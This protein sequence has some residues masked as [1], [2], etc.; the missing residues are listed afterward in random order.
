MEQQI[1]PSNPTVSSQAS[2]PSSHDAGWN[3]PP[4][5]ALSGQKESSAITSTKKFLNRRVA[6]PLGT[7]SYP[8]EKA[9]P[10]PVPSKTPPVLQSASTLTSAPH[11]PLVAPVD[12]NLPATILDNFDRNQALIEAVTNLG[13]VIT[14]Q[15]MEKSKAE[16]ILRRLNIMKSDWHENRLNDTIERNI[17]DISKGMRILFK[18]QLLHWY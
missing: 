10:P 4:K 12:K 2:L 7:Q 14:E 1:P 9:S 17:L 16:E 15:R 18:F 3:D 8:L 13:T 6:F 11:K 5:W